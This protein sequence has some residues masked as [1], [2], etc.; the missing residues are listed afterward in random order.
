MDERI[1]LTQN[2]DFR[3]EREP[4]F[5]DAHF[6]NFKKKKSDMSTFIGM[7]DFIDETLNSLATKKYIELRDGKLYIETLHES[8]L[9]KWRYDDDSHIVSCDRCG[10][11]II[12]LNRV[13]TLCDRCNDL[14]D[15]ELNRQLELSNN[16][17]IFDDVIETLPRI[18]VVHTEVELTNGE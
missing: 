14:L 11:K 6:F 17:R 3:H 7:R 18:S 1:D 4:E 16:R 5:K 9:S 13:K 15:M 10:R 8:L 12:S 2:R